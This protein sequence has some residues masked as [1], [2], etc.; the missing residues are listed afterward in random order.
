M[1]RV[2]EIRILILKE[3][4]KNL[5]KKVFFFHIFYMH[6]A[7]HQLR[8]CIKIQKK[9][10]EKNTDKSTKNFSVFFSVNIFI[11]FSVFFSVFK[12]V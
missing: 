6:V 7:K 1:N 10:M 3:I 12:Y 5:Q 8:P 9:N 2:H 4:Q 11:N